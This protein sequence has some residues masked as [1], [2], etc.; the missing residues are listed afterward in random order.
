M[1]F[2]KNGP[3]L[4][5]KFLQAHEEGKVVFFCGAG[6]SFPAG[7]PGFGQLV[8][9]LYEQLGVVPNGIQEQVLKAGQFDTA[10][11]LL[12]AERS[13]NE[14]RSDVRKK[15]AELLQPNF[16]KPKATATHRAL[17]QLAK[18]KDKKTRLITTNF[19]RIFHKVSEE[20]NLSFPSYQ[21]PLLP[22]PKNRWDGLVYLHGLLPDDF[23]KDQLDNLVISSGDFGLAYLIERWA[24]RFVSELF[25]SY[26]VCF[27]G[28]SLNDPVL[29]YMMDALAADRL[30]GEFPPE[31]FA[32][33]EFK[34]GEIETEKQQWLAKNVTP[35]LY[36]KHS[37]HHYLHETLSKWAETYRD[38]L[39]GKEQIVVT[40]ALINPSNSNLYNEHAQKLAWALSDPSGI[41]ARTFANLQPSPS[42]AWLDVLNRIKLKKSDL[43]RFDIDDSGFDDKFQFSLFRRPTKSAF[44]P[45][46]AFS[47]LHVS[48]SRWDKVME[49]LAVWFKHHLNNPDLLLFLLKS[50]GTIHSQLQRLINN[51]IEEQ[52]TKRAIEDNNYFERREAHSLD[53]VISDKMML[54]WELVLAGYC[55]LSPNNINLYSWTEKYKLSH[56]ST[57]SKRE[58]RKILSPKIE[59]KKPYSSR[60]KD[61]SNGLRAKLD[62]DICLNGSFVHSQIKELNE[63]DD[64][65]KDIAKLFP[66]FNALLIETMELKALLSDTDEFTDYT[67]IQQPSIKE[68][69]QNKDYYDWTALIELTRD[70][71]LSLSKSDDVAAASGIIT[72]WKT[73]FPI[74][75]RLALFALTECNFI[76]PDQ[77]NDWLEEK[78][79]WWLWSSSSQREL[80]Q[81]LT[82]LPARF[83]EEQCLR[84]LSNIAKG[85]LKEWYR[86]DIEDKEFHRINSRKIWLRLTKLKKSGIELKDE[87]EKLYHSI[88]IKFPEWSLS[89]DEKEEFAFWSSMGVSQNK[90][91]SSPANKNELVQWL[92]ETS[93]HTHWDQDDWPE[94]CKNDFEVTKNA[95]ITLEEDNI[96]VAERWREAL[97]I[98]SENKKLSFTTWR[99]LSKTLLDFNDQ[100]LLDISWALSNW[101]KKN[102]NFTKLSLSLNDELY[103]QYFDRL[104]ALPFEKQDEE[105]HDPITSAINHP[106]G[107]LTESLFNRWY[108]LEPH[109]GEGISEI[110]KNRLESICASESPLSILGKVIIATNILSLYRVD[111]AWT[112]EFVLPWLNWNKSKLASMCW[113]SYL[114]SPMLYKDFVIKIKDDLLDTVNH[115][116]DLG[117]HK[118]QY[119]RFL[120]YLVLQKYDEYKVKELTNAFARLPQEALIYVASTLNNSLTSSGEKFSEYWSHRVSDFLKKI[121]PRRVDL[122]DRTVEELG[123][124]CINTKEY[125]DEAFSI[126]K[127]NLRQIDDTEYLVRQT[128]ESEAISLHTAQVLEF[129]D[130]V[131]IN[132]PRFRPPSKLRDCLNKIIEKQPE[133]VNENSFRRLDTLLRQFE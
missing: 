62:W 22:V 103:F 110:F 80:L 25:R 33:G 113:H 43:L 37:N 94:R 126:I 57:A 28:Y 100:K 108:K 75:K 20:E 118:E 93:T 58:L 121:W 120:T 16:S 95:L 41:P 29:R 60:G 128:L 109:D 85:S 47:S 104:I 124:L 105:P 64:W 36:K 45:A 10:V 67:T 54:V 119:A 8:G 97:Q 51:E 98:W 9:D 107:I 78:N 70:S 48:E 133:L 38:G 73:P 56:L 31:M 13:T 53:S 55:E 99:Y 86:E 40:T 26:T 89:D 77:I 46:M 127:Y 91:S 35:I 7:L 72:W 2:V 1:Q 117:A 17:L 82:T 4:P 30:L 68:H 34:K 44:S 15:I 3:D 90:L 11:S 131:I 122:T 84:L 96:W 49:Y 123:L 61:T 21:A 59:F 63:L 39:G 65:G 14:W 112:E 24:A 116:E 66:E 18:T 5:E 42:L 50:G 129:F 101:L 74:F 92:K 23:E 87:V 125:F 32:F 69:P 81:L 52:R 102:T 6:I 27:V 79:C 106:V 115:Y 76:S 12:E 19:D 83:D 130:R 88:V 114:W 71:W 132:V 111:P